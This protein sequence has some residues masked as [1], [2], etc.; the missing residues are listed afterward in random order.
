MRSTPALIPLLNHLP[1]SRKSVGLILFLGMAAGVTLGCGGSGSPTAPST[2]TTQQ[3][4]TLL[5]DLVGNYTASQFVATEHADTTVKYDVI[6]N[7]GD[8]YGTD[9]KDGGDSS[10]FDYDSLGSDH[11]VGY[12]T[13]TM[14]TN[15]DT[16]IETSSTS[17]LNHRWTFVFYGDSI[18]VTDA[19]TT[20]SFPTSGDTLAT[21]APATVRAVYLLHQ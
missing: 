17:D 19:N 13:L 8:S 16:L 10:F 11:E 20:F 14:S 7:G 2:T 15:G 21:A 5:A 1:P 6:A 4:D 12:A 9:Y 3:Q 18:E